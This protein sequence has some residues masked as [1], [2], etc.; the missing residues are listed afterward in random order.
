MDITKTFVVKAP[1]D[2][3]WNFLTDP[4]R[5]AACLPGAAIT[6]R[7]DEQ[8]YAGTITVKVGPVAATYKGTLRFERLD[9]VSRTAELTAAGQDVK[10][11][12]G[13]D[14]RMT[15]HLVELAPGET[16]VT[17]KSEV[18]VMGVLAQFGRGMIQDVSDQMFQRFVDAMRRQLEVPA[19]A[20]AAGPVTGDSA[21]PAAPPVPDQA[22]SSSQS[23][24]RND[25]ATNPE[26]APVAVAAPTAAAG[27]DAPIP[28][29]PPIDVLSMGSQAFV[30]A[31]LRAV[32]RRR[33][34]IALGSLVAAGFTLGLLR[35]RRNRAGKLEA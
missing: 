3:A 30:R 8:T 35:R 25:P 32:R 6:E 12:G 26:L 18:S 7:R 31:A 23:F 14:L 29:S 2:V 17:V 24:E 28:A 22:S 10:G 11:R 33:V 34:Q 5:V 16:E 1:A 9:A 20:P 19:A 27:S 13:A 15:S 21:Q 4:R